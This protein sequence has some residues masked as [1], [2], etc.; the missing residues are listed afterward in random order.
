MELNAQERLKVGEVIEVEIGPVAHGGHFVARHN[1]QVIFVRH[2][3]TGEKAKIKITAVNSKIAHA[4]VTEVLSASQSRVSAPCEYAGKCGGCDFQHIQIDQQRE[5]KAAIIKE[6]F[7]RIGKIDLEQLGFNLTV[8]AVDPVAGLHWRTR[9]DFAVSPSG[10]IGFFGA[11]SNEVVEINDCLIADER[12]NVGDL[13]K[14]S[15]KSDARV[16]VAVSSTNEVSVVR[17]GRSISGPTQLVEQVG[18]SSLKI[19]PTAFWQSHRLAPTTLVKAVISQLGIKKSDHICDLY[20][21]VGLFAA[22]ILNEIGDQ[23]FVTLIESDKT[24]VA[25]ARRIFANKTNVKILQGLVAQQLPIVKR[26][27]LILLDPPRTGAGEN[28]IKQI[29]KFR[30]RKI[31]YVAC[32]PAALA[33]DS[34]TL[35]DLGYKLDHISGYDLFPMTQHIECVAGFSP[36]NG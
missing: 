34:K 22:A 16:E 4:D 30:P 5:F 18:G 13:A 26:A 33:R 17:S 7:L 31:I 3:I 32:D 25:D 10:H 14:R 8:A 15:W 21:G 12:M 27:D 29:V 36:A 35:L 19:S 24:A 2:G 1:N 9:M 6:Q 11:R 23:G 20:S 28:V